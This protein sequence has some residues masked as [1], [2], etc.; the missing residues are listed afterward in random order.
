MERLKNLIK[1]KCLNNNHMKH[2]FIIFIIILFS[3]CSS[4]LKDEPKSLKI[5]LDSIPNI[6]VDSEFEL[7]VYVEGVEDLFAMSFILYYNNALVS[8]D[9][10]M[11]F[12]NAGNY[13]PH[14]FIPYI[15][16]SFEENRISLAIGDVNSDEG[17][18]GSGDILSI[19]FKALSLGEAHFYLTNLEMI[20]SDGEDIDD[21]GNIEILNH[22]I[23]ITP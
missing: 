15:E 19:H 22:T 14:P 11:D 21:F 9:T 7:S 3:H 23:S 17:S 12:I 16:Q 13:F 5:S 1:C 2:I 10:S 4:P 8:I 6:S 20:K 18:S